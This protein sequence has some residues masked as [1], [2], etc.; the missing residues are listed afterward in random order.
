LSDFTSY[1]SIDDG[2]LI[3]PKKIHVLA[4][5]CFRDFIGDLLAV[6]KMFQGGCE[7]ILGM[8]WVDFKDFW[9]DFGDIPG[10]YL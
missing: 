1:Y 6:P 4:V 10:N 3:L 8:L 5:P 9:A 7:Q 2:V